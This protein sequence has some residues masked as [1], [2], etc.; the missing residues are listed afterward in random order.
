MADKKIES[1]VSAHIDRLRNH[2][3]ENNAVRDSAIEEAQ[4]AN[5]DEHNMTVRQALRSYPWAV[6]WC[7]SISMSIIMEEYDTNLISSF[8]GI[9]P[10]RNSSVY[11]M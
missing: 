6:F 1:P 3:E 9:P 2:G 5:I 7:L 11:S 4:V 8:T 10:F